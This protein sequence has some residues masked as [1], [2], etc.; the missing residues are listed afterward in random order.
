ME[1]GRKLL[2]TSILALIA[3]GSAGQVVVGILLAFFALIINIRLK[4]YAD[5]NLNFINQIAQ[6]NL[7]CACPR[8]VSLL[9]A[10]T[11]AALPSVF[12]FVALLLK[13]N[14]DG[15]GDSAFFTGIVGCM[16][17]GAPC[18]LWRAGRMLTRSAPASVPIGLPIFIKLYAK[19]FGG[20][21]ARMMIKDA[22]F[23]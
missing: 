20:L 8:D 13:V 3:P 21:E 5:N 11:N 19:F 12:L 1:L 17:I 14:L 10:S 4:P 9:A 23:E 2:L 22:E 18:C 15:E 7:F 6:L 16:S